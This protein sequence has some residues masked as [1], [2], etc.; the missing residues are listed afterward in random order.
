LGNWFE[1]KKM[2]NLEVYV[3]CTP[4]YGI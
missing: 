3:K 4:E 2:A 1:P